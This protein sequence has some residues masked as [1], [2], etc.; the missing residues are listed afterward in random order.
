MRCI[1]VTSIASMAHNEDIFAIEAM[2]FSVGGLNLWQSA[3]S[4]VTVNSYLFNN[5]K[6]I[7]SQ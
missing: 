6:Q 2:F 5:L 1:F 7:L 3:Q 4:N